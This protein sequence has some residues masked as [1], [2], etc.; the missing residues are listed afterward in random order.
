[1]DRGHLLLLVICIHVLYI[2][3]PLYNVGVGVFMLMCSR[4]YTRPHKAVAG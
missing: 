3:V 4:G 2:H 1:M